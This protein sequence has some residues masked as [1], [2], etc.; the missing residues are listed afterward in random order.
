LVRQLPLQQTASPQNWWVFGPQSATDT[1]TQAP[2]HQWV[3][4][5][6]LPQGL[7]GRFSPHWS[8]RVML[9]QACEAYGQAHW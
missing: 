1:V 8:G 3:T 2:E 5:I 4:K 7:Y 9:K 6:V